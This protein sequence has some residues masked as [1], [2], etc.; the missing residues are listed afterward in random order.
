MLDIK[1][2]V[3]DYSVHSISV[4]NEDCTTLLLQF[5]SRGS[6]DA[7]FNC[8]YYICVNSKGHLI[9]SDLGNKQIKVFQ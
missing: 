3:S 9:V 8:P 4:Y 1:I 5:G 2:I 6:D 7:Q